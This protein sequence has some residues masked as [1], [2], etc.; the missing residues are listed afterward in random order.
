MAGVSKHL[1]IGSVVTNIV[2]LAT[3][4][5]TVFAVDTRY[6]KAAEFQQFHQDYIE[7]DIRELKKELREAER[8]GDPEWVEDVLDEMEEL[9][10][11]LCLSYPESRYCRE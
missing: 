6:V 4:V 8:S 7:S 9:L 11:E 1:H 3:F 10:D 5:G 2:L